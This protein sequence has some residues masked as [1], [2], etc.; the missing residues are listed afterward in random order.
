MKSE[1]VMSNEARLHAVM[2]PDRKVIEAFRTRK[3]AR[4]FKDS[5]KTVFR[6]ATRV[7]TLD[8]TPEIGE[9]V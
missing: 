8:H 3:L 1:V 9:K 7:L 4:E 5:Y 6:I 2:G